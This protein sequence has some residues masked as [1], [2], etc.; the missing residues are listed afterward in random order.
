M[1]D[2]TKTPTL[3]ITT[4][5]GCSVNCKYCPQGEI[6]KNYKGEKNMSVAAHRDLVKTVPFSVPII[7]SGVSDPFLNPNTPEMMLYDYSNGH[8]LI[9]YTT[10]VGLSFD[11][12][13]LICNIPFEQ[14]T[15]H[16]PDSLGN[17]NI[18]VTDE[19]M[20]I[21]FYIIKHIKNVKFMNMGGC[22]IS[23][24]NEKY[25]RGLPV[26]KKAYPIHCFR[27]DYPHYTLMPNGDVHFCCQCKGISNRIGSLYENTYSELAA[28]H[29][30]IVKKLKNDPESI[31]HYCTVSQPIPIMKLALQAKQ[32]INGEI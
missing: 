6:I 28:K 29:K 12:A 7:N 1:I 18:P 32:I 14:F 23:D 24:E 27:F 30:V 26:K 8:K 16:L 9:C 25:F 2:I 20:K 3:E 19:Y 31:C 11:S 21:F 17:A 5:I 10:G 4:K 15:I 22:F 13:K